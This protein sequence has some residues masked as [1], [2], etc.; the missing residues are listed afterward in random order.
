MEAGSFLPGPGTT[1][2]SSLSLHITAGSS[3]II[4]GKRTGLARPTGDTGHNHEPVQVPTSL[5]RAAYSLAM[6][7]VANSDLSSPPQS[8]RHLGK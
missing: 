4:F 2:V 5:H 7:R 8:Q 3:T 1:G 6:I